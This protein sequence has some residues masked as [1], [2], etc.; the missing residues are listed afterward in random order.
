[1]SIQIGTGNLTTAQTFN[2]KLRLYS[3]NDS[4][5]IDMDSSTCNVIARYG[6]YYM[7]QS[8]T[9]NAASFVMRSNNALLMTMNNQNTSIL[10]AA[11]QFSGTVSASNMVSENNILSRGLVDSKTLLTRQLEVYADSDTHP[12]SNVFLISSDTYNLWAT[13]ASANTTIIGNVGIGTFPLAA[14]HVA[15]DARFDSNLR[16]SNLFT[17]S[18]VSARHPDL[19]IQFD[20]DRIILTGDTFIRGG[21]DAEKV[22]F[23]TFVTSNLSLSYYEQSNLEGAKPS[24]KMFHRSTDTRFTENVMEI[25]VEYHEDPSLLHPTLYINPD[26]LVGIGTRMPTH[27]LHV[28]L[29]DLQRES[30]YGVFVAKNAAHPGGVVAMDCNIHIGI[31]TTLPKTPLHI[32]STPETVPSNDTVMLFESTDVSRD[33]ILLMSACNGE[34][35]LKLRSDG[36]IEASAVKSKV[37]HLDVITP[38]TT[39]A[40]SFSSNIVTDIAVLNASN[41]NVEIVKG[42]NGVFQNL[43]AL[44]VNY[45]LPGFNLGADQIQITQQIKK[46]IVSSECALFDNSANALA[47]AANQRADIPAAGKVRIIVDEPMTT[48]SSY[49]VEYARGLV[50]DGSYNDIEPGNDNYNKSVALS[51]ITTDRGVAMVE[52]LSTTAILD[53]ARYNEIGEIGY[54]NFEGSPSIYLGFRS[55]PDIFKKPLVINNN[56]AR[57]TLSVN[58]RMLVNLDAAANIDNFAPAGTSMY[59]NGKTIFG[60]VNEDI[61]V[62]IDSDI[63]SN[64][65]IHTTTPSHTLHVVGD[66]R[67]SNRLILDPGSVATFGGI[68]DDE[69]RFDSNVYVNGRIYSNGHVSTTSD[70]ELKINLE[71]IPEPLEKIQKISGYTYNRIDRGGERETGLVAQEVQAILPEVVFKDDASSFL[72]IAYGSM[73][74]LFVESIKALTEKVEALQKEVAV[75]KAAQS[76]APS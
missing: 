44:N 19:A 35:N 48:P 51:L 14:L 29:Q 18:V 37:A 49:N 38:A 23:A 15:E 62:T 69:T 8:N 39:P 20:S 57:T 22:D 7:G 71:R 72:S 12:E 60:N 28:E 55:P 56:G 2:E 47:A 54:Y 41:I 46:F 3:R 26:G 76:A 58:A 31:G 52:M 34:E 10:T 59:V 17:N 74:G 50:I 66:V 16:T 24:F 63:T 61:I 36:Y 68:I 5:I 25:D 6:Q 73:A 30:A 65:G 1:M 75:L 32:W 45:T 64:V 43:T 67:I 9:S 4:P 11:A 40:I 70:R 53:P 21:F 27:Q 13:D 33:V 42:M